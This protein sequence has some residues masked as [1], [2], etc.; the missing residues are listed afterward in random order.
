MKQNQIVY[1]IR[2]KLLF[3]GESKFLI[4]IKL[5]CKCKGRKL[6]LENRN[7]FFL[8]ENRKKLSRCDENV[9]KQQRGEY[10]E[11]EK[12]QAKHLPILVTLLDEVTNRCV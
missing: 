4:I 1:A 9:R 12:I 5:T 10:V 11:Y 7:S 8:A 6:M 3:P 2:D